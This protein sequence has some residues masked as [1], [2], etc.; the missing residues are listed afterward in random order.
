[1][2]RPWAPDAWL[3]RY[4][5][6]EPAEQDR[7]RLSAVSIFSF[8]VPFVLSAVWSRAFPVEYFALSM[9]LQTLPGAISGWAT[10]G[11]DTAMHTPR[12]DA[13]AF[14]V[15]RLSMCLV[16]IST[17][18][19]A[20]LCALCG[21]WVARELFKH[22]EVAG[23]LWTAPTVLFATATTMVMDNWLARQRMLRQMSWAILVQTLFGPVIPTFGLLAPE[24]TNYIVL[25]G[26]FSS[27]LGAVVRLV[28]GDFFGRWRRYGFQLRQMAETARRFSNFPREVL[29]SQVLTSFSS[30]IATLM[31][32]PNFG[33]ETVAHY[34]RAPT[35]L[36]FPLTVLAKPN[37]A[38]F[39]QEAGRAYREEGD[40][41]KVIWTTL[42]RL[43]LQMTPVYL[44]LG[45]LAPYVYPLYYGPAWQETG[46]MA[47]PLAMYYWALTVL[48]PIGDV[49]AFGRNTRW[50]L[51]WQAMRL[52]ALVGALWVGTRLGG[53][54]ATLW[55]LSATHV[56]LY[57]VYVAMAFR[58]GVRR[59]E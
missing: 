13:D 31:I 17:G 21:D 58:L 47:Q 14:E 53:I 52:P 42:R 4:R 3:E 59:E 11:Y 32:V 30:Q 18:V 1:M 26:T 7:L 27:L 41:R 20:L 45:G 44:V 49:M 36:K 56:A 8:V 48:A 10:L 37:M 54:L 28:Q 51:A 12:D 29:P 9:V 43:T 55:I 23:W 34:S 46:R 35:L 24:R 39:T 15:V 40:C 57:L 33:K 16:A 2:K 25:A 19:L 5:L 22:P 38:V 50:D 6:A